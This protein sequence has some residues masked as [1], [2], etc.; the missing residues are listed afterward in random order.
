MGEV[1]AP[2]SMTDLHSTST[3]NCTLPWPLNAPYMFSSRGFGLQHTPSTATYELPELMF[4]MSAFEDPSLG[5]E[6]GFSGVGNAEN[7]ALSAVHPSEV[8]S[9]VSA[10]KPKLKNKR[11]K[12]TPRSSGNISAITRRPKFWK[13]RKE[14]TPRS[15]ENTS[16]TA[17]GFRWLSTCIEC[18]NTASGWLN[19]EDLRNDPDIAKVSSTLGCNFCKPN[20][21]NEDRQEAK[22]R[23]LLV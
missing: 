3:P 23:K 18:H 13:G 9:C 19:F 20:R 22:N 14:R 1:V 11:K 10:K 17:H 8:E 6:V 7:V 4:P 5:D 16:A 12:R 21:G 2:S 15:S